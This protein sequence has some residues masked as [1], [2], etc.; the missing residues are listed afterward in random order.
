MSDERIASLNMT[1][2]FKRELFMYSFGDIKFKKPS[3]LKSLAF[4]LGFL[5][6]WTLPLFLVFGIP[7]NPVAAII[8]LVPPIALGQVASRPIFGGK[9][10]IDFVKTA[11]LFLGEPKG[12]ADMRPFNATESQQTYTTEHEIWISRRREYALL[13][14]MIDESEIEASAAS[15]KKS[16]KR[17]AAKPSK[18][19]Q[20]K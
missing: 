5:L 1:G 13:A 15:L 9:T 6:V 10:L 11:I 2:F 4:T 19:S 8:Y 3:A 17:T 14:Q 7:F 12:W 16:K 20:K 18:K